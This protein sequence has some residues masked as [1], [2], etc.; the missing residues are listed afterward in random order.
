MAWSLAV[1]AYTDLKG[2]KG[3]S[4]GQ[5]LPA[6]PLQGTCPAAERLHEGA[7]VSNRRLAWVEAFGYAGT[8]CETRCAPSLGHGAYLLQ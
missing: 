8:P 6:L 3:G 2:M 1:S 5:G 7:P 4:D